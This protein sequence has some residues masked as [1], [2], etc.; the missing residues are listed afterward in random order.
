MP[1]ILLTAEVTAPIER[2]F[3]LSRSIDFHMHS[4][5]RTGEQAIAGVTK[6]LIGHAQL[7]TW[8]ARHFWRWRE[9]TSRISEFERPR[10]FVDE[11]VRGDFACFRHEHLFEQLSGGR[12]RMEDRFTFAAPWGPLGRLAEAAFLTTYV[13]G[14]L[15]ERTALLQASLESD[16]WRQFLTSTD[17]EP[18]P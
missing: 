3:D 15:K 5:S 9:L 4:M 11:M 6:G 18:H 1:T 12:T 14:L 13:R 8:R 10:R 7:V 16:G 2:C 17:M